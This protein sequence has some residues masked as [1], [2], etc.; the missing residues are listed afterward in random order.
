RSDATGQSQQGPGNRVSPLHGW[1]DYQEP[2][3]FSG[4]FCIHINGL[5][6]PAAAWKSWRVTFYVVTADDYEWFGR[7]RRAWDLG[8]AAR[9][10]LEPVLDAPPTAASA[11]DAAL[12]VHFFPG[13]WTW[14]RAVVAPLVDAALDRAG[15]TPDLHALLDAF[16][17]WE[18]SAAH[19]T[20]LR[21]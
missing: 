14:N 10:G 16:R 3:V 18:A 6:A 1:L 12:A 15:G 17:D 20:P 19:I 9:R 21:V 4:P 13:M 2:G 5:A 7:C 8:A 11:R